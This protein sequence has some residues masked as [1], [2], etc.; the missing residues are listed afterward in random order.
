[1]ESSM[2]H[3]STLPSFCSNTSSQQQLD[4]GSANPVE[5]DLHADLHNS[6]IQAV[7]MICS[8]SQYTVSIDNLLRLLMAKRL[9]KAKVGL[10]ATSRRRNGSHSSSTLP[11]LVNKTSSTTSMIKAGAMTSNSASYMNDG[12][13]SDDSESFGPLKR[14]SSPS[15]SLGMESMSLEHTC[16]D[17]T[18]GA[19][20][21]YQVTRKDGALHLLN[22]K[23]GK[24]DMQ[25]ETPLFP[26]RTPSTYDSLHARSD[27]RSTIH[28]K[29]ESHKGL[30]HA[31]EKGRQVGLGKDTALKDPLVNT[32]PRQEQGVM[33]YASTR[34]MQ[35]ALN[36]NMLKESYTAMVLWH[37]IHT[38]LHDFQTITNF[39]GKAG[40]DWQAHKQTSREIS[41]KNALLPALAAHR[42]L[43]LFVK[44]LDMRG[45]W[46][47]SRPDEF[48]KRV[49]FFYAT[50]L[51]QPMFPTE[52][53]VDGIQE[54][55][56]EL[57]K[58]FE[59]GE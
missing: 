56:V 38:R 59:V 1:M 6:H 39:T 52:D 5:G 2:R 25:Q 47:A 10:N 32:A 22:R 58:W 15:L 20:A 40:A 42:E 12:H 13:N 54:Y 11:E 48:A 43:G 50:L 26:T 37:E 17:T 18:L 19:H 8:L 41:W 29:E 30:Q 7:R 14:E 23:H 36:S 53:L 33:T 21:N 49:A 9:Y 44:V 16:H 51:Q 55:N 34:R 35:A 3:E 57:L 31:I 45:E 4:L 27:E 28:T 24:L 46:V